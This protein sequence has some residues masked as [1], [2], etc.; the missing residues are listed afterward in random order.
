MDVSQF[1]GRIAKIRARFATKLAD[2]IQQTDAALPS[3]AGAGSEAADAVAAAYR[4][5]HDVCGVGATIGFVAIGRLARTLDTILVV[6]FRDHRGL[7]GDELAHFKEGLE[8]L[9]AAAQTEMQSPDP[10]RELAQ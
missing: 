6:A 1:A 3:L 8:S 10:S 9:R 5:F 7:S 4:R 2:N